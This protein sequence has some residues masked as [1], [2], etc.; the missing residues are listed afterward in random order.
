M[1][2]ELPPSDDESVESFLQMSPDTF[3]VRYLFWPM[4]SNLF[5]TCLLQHSR[6]IITLGIEHMPSSHRQHTSTFYLNF[7]ILY[8]QRR[9]DIA[10]SVLVDSGYHVRHPWAP[11]LCV[12]VLDL[13]W[14]FGLCVGQPAFK[15]SQH[16]TLLPRKQESNACCAL[17]HNRFVHVGWIIRTM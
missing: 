11:S 13:L 4:W 2:Q 12:G 5:A 8:L 7:M 15:H 10:A 1:C 3:K 9:L 16:T 17:P 6:A 14:L